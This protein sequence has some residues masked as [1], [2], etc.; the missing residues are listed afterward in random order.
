M[1]FRKALARQA[2][3]RATTLFITKVAGAYITFGQDVLMSDFFVD[4]ETF[5]LKHS[6]DREEKETLACLQI[7]CVRFLID[8]HSAYQLYLL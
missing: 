8:A 4:E 7:Q 3:I 1:I 6:M 5:K 2:A